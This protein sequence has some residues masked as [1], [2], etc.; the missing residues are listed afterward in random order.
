MSEVAFG[1]QPL[2]A[3]AARDVSTLGQRL[4]AQ[5]RLP[6]LTPRSLVDLEGR[7]E[8][9]ARFRRWLA[10][11]GSF[12]SVDGDVATVADRLRVRWHTRRRDPV[13]GWHENDHTA[14]ATVEDGLVVALDVACAGFRPAGPAES[15]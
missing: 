15:P 3:I 5:A 8:D 4:A 11:M 7:E 14:C 13:K 2:G 6:V 12:V 10:D 9:V 1:L